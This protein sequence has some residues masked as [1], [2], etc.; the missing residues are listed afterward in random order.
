MTGWITTSRC[1]AD[2][3]ARFQC[4]NRRGGLDRAGGA[5]GHEHGHLISG[6]AKAAEVYPPRLVAAILSGLRRQLQEDGKMSVSAL[7][8]GAHGHDEES[9]PEEDVEKFYDDI[10]G[11]LLPTKLVREARLEEIKFLQS[12]PVYKKVPAEEA[13]GKQKVSVR[14]RDVNKGDD[15]RHR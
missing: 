2:E 1:I 3:L 11:K 4:R 8:P 7:E 15:R 5:P 12:F 9:V 14:W 10:S 13:R 6:R